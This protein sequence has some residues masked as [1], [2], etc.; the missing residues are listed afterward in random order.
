MSSIVKINK[1]LVDNVKL[2]KLDKQL[3]V[4]IFKILNKDNENISKDIAII[5]MSCKFPDADNLKEYWENLLN[6]RASIKKY[7]KR[8]MEDTFHFLADEF[9][10]EALSEKEDFF[11]RAGYLDD[12][13]RFDAKFFNISP[14]EVKTID[15]FHRLF[16]ETTYKTME[17]A[18]YGGKKLV[19]S[20]TGVFVGVDHGAKV[21]YTQY[22]F[23]VGF[24]DV[25]GS[26]DSILSSRISY[27][28]NLKGPCMTIDTSCSSGLVA[29]NTAVNVLRNKQ[30][31]IALVG[32]I[33]IFLSPDKYRNGIGQM[34]TKENEFR[35]FDK[36]AS[37]SKWG[38]GVGVLMLKPLNKAVED[39]DNIYA[40]IKG[41][42][43]NNNGSNNS[44]T[45]LSASAQTD[46]IIKAWKD[47]NVEPETI[48]YI[49]AH[50]AGTIINDSLE[51][52][53][54]SDAFRKYTDKKQFCGI[55]SIKGNVGH[56]G[57]AASIGSI[58]KVAMSLKNKIIPATLHF[59]EPNPFIDF[60][61]SP[62]YIND[63][64]KKW[65]KKDGL[66][67]AGVSAFGFTA[68]NGHI[69][70]EEAPIISINE[71]KEEYNIFAIS[72]KTEK[73]II[74]YVSAIHKYLSESKEVIEL[75]DICYTM[76]CGRGHYNYRMALIVQS[77][78][79][80][81]DKLEL[82]LQFGLN[83]VQIGN[84]NYEEH[85]IVSSRSD[86]LEKGE[87][88]QDTKIKLENEL[89]KKVIDCGDIYNLDTLKYIARFYVKGIDSFWQRMYKNKGYRK[90]SL[91]IYPLDRKRHWK[92]YDKKNL[93]DYYKKETIY[94]FDIKEKKL[95]KNL[96][97]RMS[98]QSEEIEVKIKGN[99]EDKYS[100]EEIILA[101]IWGNVL[102]FEE[103]NIKDD[104][105]QIGGDSIIAIKFVNAINSYLNI[106]IGVA[107]IMENPTIT[108]LANIVNDDRYKTN[109]NS[110]FYNFKV[111]HEKREYY[112]I[113]AI[114]SG[115]FKSDLCSSD[116]T[117]NNI[118]VIMIVEGTLDINKLEEAFNKLIDRHNSLRTTFHFIEDK[119]L[120][121]VHSSM[122]F[123]ID[124]DEADEE[125]ISLQIKSFIKPFLLDQLPLIR[126]KILKVATK[127][128]YLM[129]DLHHI[130]SD[131]HTISIL[132]NEMLL[133]YYGME[134]PKLKIQYQDYALWQY[135]S[136][137]NG[138]F[139]AQEEYWHNIFSGE[140]PQSI[141]PTDFERTKE[142][143]YEG[144]R[145][146]FQLD[147]SKT[148]SVKNIAAN[149]E[150]TTFVFLLT[151]L[152]IVVA[153]YCASE[154]VVIGSPYIGR[155]HADLENMIGAFIN[156]I[157]IRS[158]PSSHKKFIDFIDEVKKSIFS[159]Y[160]NQDY[161]FDILLN[162]IDVK[163]DFNKSPIFNI[164]FSVQDVKAPEILI[165][166]LKM[167]PYERDNR[168]I[169]Y[170]IIFMGTEDE[171]RITF[172]LDYC[173]SLYNRE[174]MLQFKED[175]LELINKIIENPNILIGELLLNSEKNIAK[176]N[177]SLIEDFSF[178]F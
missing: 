157:P 79:E 118:P 82:I 56:M 131:A 142:K 1:L 41:C 102:G 171:E 176:R 105:F 172:T 103:I 66:R 149:H 60:H 70:L 72:A 40:V 76:N 65:I 5:G 166:D 23:N 132:F 174:T 68:T 129:V 160:N 159:A 29:I 120:Q 93:D 116:T 91:P 49:E 98:S 51:V 3:A 150:T 54:L 107:D 167:I 109:N 122:E 178:N 175:Y 28:Y 6:E 84:M 25:I 63:K 146:V 30:C 26:Y 36:N 9:I 89:M 85:R 11:F 111:N 127:R 77:K 16:L 90:V 37:G 53:G 113:T 145:L 8:R 48:D 74:D 137:T 73:Q 162:T 92:I 55:G 108:E 38:E 50:G 57:G 24:E 75:Q 119:P 46:V 12:I 64:N 39:K 124:Y 100:N 114:Q 4:D 97:K 165:N 14:N 35:V 59:D 125:E 52:R 106:K 177:P 42:G 169:L 136:L 19:G 158:Y 110:D 31:S 2:G 88:T 7:P 164:V 17:D 123:N 153:K 95:K 94:H 99:K 67:R 128:Y 112:P 134:L 140:L 121:K 151:I 86:E 21:K 32:G 148:V 45:S 71:K 58:I 13:D 144:D 152:N 22:S 83:G 96:Y 101:N 34:E 130:I 44:I 117:V 155:P 115:F 168:E 69:V 61:N 43:V 126:V 33:N 161:P 10:P 163:R 81:I 27:L 47:S 170:D 135:E 133:I 104:F 15:P 173:C 139:K 62:M 141:I 80:L 20:N 18:G 154:D 138:N 78:E 156:M 87:I 143:S 147:D